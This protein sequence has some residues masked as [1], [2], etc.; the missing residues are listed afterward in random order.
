[1][2]VHRQ[3]GEGEY[4]VELEGRFSLRVADDDPFRLRLMIL[5]LRLLE[6]PEERRGGRRTRD[7]RT[8]FV[9]QQY[10][11]GTLGIP[12]PVLSRWEGYWQE[13]D[14]RRLLSARAKEVLSLELQQRIIETWAHWPSWG[15]QQVHRFLIGQG[16][17]V[18]ESQ[19]RQAAHE[20]GWQIVR[21][22][23]GRLCV[24]RAEALRLREH[25]LVGD[26]LGQVMTLLEKVETGQGLTAE[27]HL[28]VKAWQATVVPATWDARDAKGA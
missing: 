24:Q 25:W 1:V 3:P 20:S 27:E 11:A 2:L 21:Q 17:A 23:L 22:V 12:Q 6:V 7:G 9:R 10:L 16:V 18:T 5:F 13:A 8:P 19:V 15:L 4:L 28:D 26:L 14:W